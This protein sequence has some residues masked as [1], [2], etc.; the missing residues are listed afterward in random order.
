MLLMEEVAVAVFVDHRA[1]HK[2]AIF[3]IFLSIIRSTYIS[4]AVF[5]FY[6]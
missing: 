3:F 4:F 2:V 5:F 1:S 6:C